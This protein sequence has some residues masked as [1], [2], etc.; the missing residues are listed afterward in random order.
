MGSQTLAKEDN[1]LRETLVDC[2]AHHIYEELL[3]LGLCDGVNLCIEVVQV[4]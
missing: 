4:E 1:W 2:M 3:L